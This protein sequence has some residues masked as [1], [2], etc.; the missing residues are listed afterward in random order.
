MYFLT[1]QDKRTVGQQGNPRTVIAKGES[2]EELVKFYEDLIDVE[3]KDFKPETILSNFVIPADD[4]CVVEWT[5]AGFA[6]QI[7]AE[8]DAA[9]DHYAKVKEQ[10]SKIGE[11]RY[12]SFLTSTHSPKEL[13]DGFAKFLAEETKAPALE[14]T[15]G[16]EVAVAEDEMAAMDS[17]EEAAIAPEI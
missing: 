6:E 10:A 15:A 9:M 12:N 7:S 1:L 16:E 13:I 2:K 4:A 14:A 17:L 3:A 5:P 8:A 11:E